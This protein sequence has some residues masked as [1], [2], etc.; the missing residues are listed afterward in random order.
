MKPIGALVLVL[1]LT[2]V[3]SAMA[4]ANNGAEQIALDGG[5]RG[6]VPFPH[7]RHQSKLGDCDIC[8][9]LFP[10]EQG[11]I[12]RLKKEGRLVAK[13]IMN[14]HCIKCHKA[15]MQAGHPAGPVTCS[16]CHAKG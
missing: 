7:H 14:K 8:H 12:E 10:Q 11:A 13:Q 15:E 9:T 3:L 2:G 1:A 5:D 6:V 4:M 16:K